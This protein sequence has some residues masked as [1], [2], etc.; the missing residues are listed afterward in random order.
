MK[1][2]KMNL[3]NSLY[4]IK[5]SKKEISTKTLNRAITFVEITETPTHFAKL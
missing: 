3:K 5:D 2:L 4:C 1:I